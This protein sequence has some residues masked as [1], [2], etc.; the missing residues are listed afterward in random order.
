MQ[1]VLHNTEIELDVPEKRCLKCGEYW[2]E[3]DE[4]F[5][6]LPN[7]HLHGPCKACIDERRR[8]VAATKPC[9]IPGC[10]NPRYHW[11]YARCWEHRAYLQVNPHPR[12]YK[13][14]EAVR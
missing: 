11:R 5:P 6:R 14:K 7:G 2:P 13:R 10:T 3:T 1:N 9:V 4:F 8:E 12:G